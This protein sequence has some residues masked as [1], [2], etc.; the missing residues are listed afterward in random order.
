MGT[1]KARWT[2][3]E[4]ERLNAT[5]RK[6]RRDSNRRWMKVQGQVTASGFNKFLGLG[7]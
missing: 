3:E 6:T 2:E 7:W 1:N 4:N 5:R